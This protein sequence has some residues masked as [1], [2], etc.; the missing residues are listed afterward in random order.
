M[1][2]AR[3]RSRNTSRG[4][5]PGHWPL[6]TSG[7]LASSA[8]ANLR[9]LG[10]RQTSP[11]PCSAR[12]CATA[13]LPHSGPLAAPPEE[14]VNDRIEGDEAGAEREL[15]RPAELVRIEH[16]QQV[17]FNEATGITSGTARPSQCVF[18]RGQRA[19]RAAELDEGRPREHRQ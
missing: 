13:A 19:H 18:Q 2:C 9:M 3:K 16:G 11:K 17:V 4:C 15:E 8:M 12:P 6:R 10:L 5:R 7:A 1:N 14:E